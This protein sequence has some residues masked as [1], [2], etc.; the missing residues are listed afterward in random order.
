MQSD[1]S[2]NARSRWAQLRLAVYRTS[3]GTATVALVLRQVDGKHVFDRKLRTGQVEAPPGS[4]ASTDPIAAC[5]LAL[6]EC[7]TEVEWE[8]ALHE[9]LETR[10]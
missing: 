6:R 5:M 10:R 3:G 1:S 8:R 7:S 9:A 4:L 2:A